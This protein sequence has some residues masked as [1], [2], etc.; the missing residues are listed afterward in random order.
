MNQKAQINSHHRNIRA[1][2]NKN[3]L[4]MHSRIHKKLIS[5]AV[6]RSKENNTASFNE[7]LQ[8]QIK[9]NL[10]TSI[11]DKNQRQICWI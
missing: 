11:G 1:A 9:E 6:Q 7:K 5:E 3:N 10:K 8:H 4:S 2:L